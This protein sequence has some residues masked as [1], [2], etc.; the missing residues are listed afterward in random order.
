M[1]EDLV[2]KKLLEHDERF[3]RIENTMATK[4]EFREL[5]VLVEEV[6]TI[7]KG[8][9]KEQ[10]AQASWLGRLQKN[11]ER[12]DKDIASIKTNLKMA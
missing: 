12:Q 6:V 4:D 9:Q 7:T 11:D 10:V 8:I 5:K 2:I 3:D 1:N